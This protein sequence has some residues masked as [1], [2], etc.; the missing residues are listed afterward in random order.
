MADLNG[1]QFMLNSPGINGKGAFT[2]AV[3]I[4]N[5]N[6][7]IQADD[8]QH[9]P[10]YISQR[11]PIDVAVAEN[12]PNL[13]PDTNLGVN[14]ELSFSLF[15]RFGEKCESKAHRSRCSGSEKRICYLA[16]LLL[17]NPF[18]VIGYLDNQP[19]SREIFNNM[20]LN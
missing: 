2:E 4:N 1:V 7:G 20:K 6:L 16:Q 8:C 11:D 18:S 13:C 15:G 14:Q 17:G 10:G 12:R 9:S 5:V 3:P 19:V